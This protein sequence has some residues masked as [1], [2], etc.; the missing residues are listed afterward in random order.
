LFTFPE[1]TKSKSCHAVIRSHSHTHDN[2]SDHDDRWGSHPDGDHSAPQR[3]RARYRSQPHTALASITTPCP[4]HTQPHLAPPCIPAQGQ[5]T[6]ACFWER[7]RV[8][9]SLPLTQRTY[10]DKEGTRGARVSVDAAT[11]AQSCAF[12]RRCLAFCKHPPQPLLRPPAG[13]GVA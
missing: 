3:S 10:A 9:L 8:L 4:S 2:M 7:H 11:R 1:S 12:A 5:H 13:V 6:L